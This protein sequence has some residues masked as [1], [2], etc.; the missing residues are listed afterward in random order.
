D[1]AD[2]VAT[3]KKRL[4]RQV[5][6]RGAALEHL[7]ERHVRNPIAE[8]VLFS[9]RKFPTATGKVQL[10]HEAVT[11]PTLPPAD[12]P[13]LLMAVSTDRAQS[14]QWPAHTQDGPA[15]AVVHPDAATGFADGDLA[16]VDSET[17]S[18]VVELAF[19]TGQR[20]DLLLMEKGG[21]MHAGR[22][23]NTLVRARETDAGGCAV[24]YD[25]PVRL[26]PVT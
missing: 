17:G 24:Y 3:W 18:L 6:D 2:D 13:L 5:A 25:T 11:E 21:W 9:D 26:S 7:R 14:S 4:L 1:M 10:I 19:D 22:C 12:R 16:K 15:T 23:A 8:E 20:R